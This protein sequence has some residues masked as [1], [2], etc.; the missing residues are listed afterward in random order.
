MLWDRGDWEIL[1]G[2]PQESLKKGKLHFRLKGKKLKGEWTLVRMRGREELG[3]EPWLLIKSGEDT[4]P[5]SP[6]MDNH[7]VSSGKT[8]EEI[9][10]GRSRIWHSN[11]QADGKKSKPTATRQ[12]LQPKVPPKSRASRNLLQL[13]EEFP[14]QVPAYIEPMKALLVE[15]PPQEQGWAYEIKWDGYRALTVRKGDS[16]GL[17]SR[18][19]R[20]ITKDFP[21]IAEAVTRLPVGS[22]VLDGELVAVDKQG[23]ASFQLLQNFKDGSGH[24]GHRLLYYVFDIL[25]LENHD[26]KK[27]PFTERKRILEAVLK[28]VS[29]PIRYSAA[30]EGDP[31]V[32]LAEAKKNRIEGLIGKRLDSLYEAGRRSRAWIKLKVSLEQ[33]FVIG[34]YTE[35]KGSRPYFGALLIGYYD[36]GRLL[37]ASKV[38]TGFD[39]KTLKELY[40]KFQK[41]RAEAFPFANVPTPA[42]G[43]TQGL[44]RAEMRRCT[45]LKPKL[46]CQV[47]FTEWTNDGGLRHPVFLGLR[48]DKSAAEV[49]RE[50]PQKLQSRDKAARSNFK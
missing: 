9:A 38:G 13:V 35:P 29:H 12:P 44:S 22:V 32:L 49:V 27:V 17:Y 7:S 14:R 41:L 20:D 39:T 25:N 2:D 3:K 42:G 18:R 16:V 34:G 4:K 24:N 1:G 45:W 5:I 43:G 23:H 37:F 48:D 6:K 11:R 21:E 19:A 30:F 50:T 47:R 26:L 31:E 28:N 15:R 36:E 46:V 10:G 40:T 33:E 8:L